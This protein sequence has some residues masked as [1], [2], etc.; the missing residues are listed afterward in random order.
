MSTSGDG[1]TGVD[2]LTGGPRNPKYLDVPGAVS[3]PGS[4]TTLSGQVADL[5][6][7]VDALTPSAGQAA[8]TGRVLSEVSAAR[9]SVQS[10]RS[11]II[12]LAAALFLVVGG[13]VGG[14]AWVYSHVQGNEDRISALEAQQ[15]LDVNR[16]AATRADI[17]DFCDT[18][19]WLV[20]TA[21]PDQVANF[22]PRFTA[23]K[24]SAT[25]L[26]CAGVT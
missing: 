5:S 19:D 22:G 1:G 18:Y 25:R 14:L 10:V 15:A 9:E 21:T 17:H 26:R 2:P 3:I 20:T 7:R 11:W 24:A 6:A 12:G 23:L 16:L 8:A 13:G 4:F